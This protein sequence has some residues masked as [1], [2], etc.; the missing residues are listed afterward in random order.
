MR[1]HLFIIGVLLNFL[2]GSTA[3][4]F[5]KISTP[6]FGADLMYDDESKLLFIDSIRGLYSLDI[7]TKRIECLLNEDFLP[8]S[9]VAKKEDILLVFLDKSCNLNLTKLHNG[10]REE[11][12]YSRPVK[13]RTFYFPRTTSDNS[14]I[15]FSEKIVSTNKTYIEI[16]D[17]A[18][19]K[20]RTIT[21]IYDFWPIYTWDRNGQKLYYFNETKDTRGFHCWDEKLGKS[22]TLKETDNISLF[23]SYPQLIKRKFMLFVGKDHKSRPILG[24]FNTEELTISLR[25]IESGHD[26][27]MSLFFVDDANF[28][29]QTMCHKCAELE[30]SEFEVYLS[31]TNF[32]STLVF[33]DSCRTLCPIG[34]NRILGKFLFFRDE[35]EVISVNLEDPREKEELLFSVD[36]DVKSG[37]GVETRT[38]INK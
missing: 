12:V 28:V 31:D 35:R 25:Y 29:Y 5:D 30:K 11:N 38:S 22:K 27:Y 37:T 34:Y 9:I 33:K 17:V 18:S 2:T 1:R 36:G 16:L 4:A 13:E 24:N 19:N 14:K 7:L 26:L 10:V 6:P 20:K 23:Y 32:N 3:I 8:Y 15:A 21:E